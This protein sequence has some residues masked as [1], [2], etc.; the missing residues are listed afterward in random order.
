VAVPLLAVLVFSFAQAQESGGRRRGGAAGDA[1][2]RRGGD[3]V[4][5]RERMMTALKEQMG[6]SDEE[7]KALSP[8]IEKIS[9]LSRETRP[10][11]G[12]F[13]RGR[14]T[15]DAQPQSDVGKAQADLRKALEDKSTPAE[16]ITKKLTTYREA[17]DK[18]TT[19][20][21]TLQKELKADVK[22]RQEAVLVIN[23]I[24]N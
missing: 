14:G 15:P 4:Q 2:G 21:R 17:R 3:P 20:L 12:S 11:M 8:K 7:W 19:E 13:G 18:A 6:A 16:D 9:A 23:G 22:G 10:M 24:L 5:M 1:A